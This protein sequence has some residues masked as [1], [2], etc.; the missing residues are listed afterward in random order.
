[1]CSFL[2][3]HGRGDADM[4]LARQKRVS[5]TACAALAEDMELTQY[6]QLGESFEDT[7]PTRNMKGELLEAV[8]GA[9]YQDSG[10]RLGPVRQVYGQKV[11]GH[12]VASSH[13]VSHAE[14]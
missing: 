14:S 4:T 1:M 12:H 7:K 2:T 11:H 5:R 8:L 3:H 9:I 10:F 13:D 6:L